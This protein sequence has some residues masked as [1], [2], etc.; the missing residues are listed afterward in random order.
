MDKGTYFF[1]LAYCLFNFSNLSNLK[2]TAPLNLY[3]SVGGVDVFILSQGNFGKGGGEGG[4][5]HIMLIPCIQRLK[6]RGKHTTAGIR[7]NL[8][9]PQFQKTWSEWRESLGEVWACLALQHGG[10]WNPESELPYRF[11]SPSPRSFIPTLLTASVQ[12]FLVKKG[13]VSTSQ[14]RSFHW[15]IHGAACSLC[16][17]LKNRLEVLCPVKYFWFP[18]SQPGPIPPSSDAHC[19]GYYSNTLGWVSSPPK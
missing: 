4:V 19:K 18:I 12:F 14:S 6:K 16:L 10:R 3:E 13:R 9:E 2:S 17:H 5:K 1:G 11:P 7:L 8:G 15:E